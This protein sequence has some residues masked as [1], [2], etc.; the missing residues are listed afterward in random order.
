[1]KKLCLLMSVL[2]GSFLC[3]ENA[4]SQAFVNEAKDTVS[5]VRN[6][7]KAR[8]RMTNDTLYRG[9]ASDT[10]ISRWAFRE[11]ADFCFEADRTAFF[12]KGEL[13]GTL[14]N[15]ADV[16]AGDIVFVRTPAAFFEKIHPQIKHPY[17]LITHGDVNDSFRPAFSAYLEDKKIIAWFGIHPEKTTHPKFIP[18]PLG[19]VGHKAHYDKRESLNEFFIRLRTATVKDKLVYMNFE[20]SHRADRKMCRQLFAEESFCLVG[21]RKPFMD[22]L[23][24]MAR[25]KFT[26]SPKGIGIDCYRTWEALLAGSIPVVTSSQLDPLYKELPILVIE[27]WNQLS[28]EF[29]TKKYKEITAKKYNIEKLY[30][31]YW[32]TRIYQQREKFLKAYTK[33]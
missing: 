23:S 13:T 29:L 20:D 31:E 1:M 9:E 17:I 7:L 3:A 33:K 18:I 14:F 8:N 10:F 6:E 21:D 26:L 27:D 25:C 19:I 12:A 15:P 28:E 24:E 4:S 22:Y 32:S 16:K 30:I 2:G 11:I 5:V